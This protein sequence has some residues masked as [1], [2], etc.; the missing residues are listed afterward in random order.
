MSA[1][2]FSPISQVDQMH[3]GSEP[4]QLLETQKK[5]QE[6]IE[7]QKK[8]CEEMKETIAQLDNSIKQ[9]EMENQ[10]LKDQL[11]SMHVKE[12]QLKEEMGHA[13]NLYQT[14]LELIK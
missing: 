2:P 12:E 13:K 3:I 1:L 5:D 14:D 8:L 11:L 7:S 6:I 4:S 9:L 10:E